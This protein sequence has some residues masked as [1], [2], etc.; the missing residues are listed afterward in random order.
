MKHV[1]MMNTR[2]G[3][4]NTQ[5]S[6]LTSHIENFNTA[7]QQNKGLEWEIKGVAKMFEKNEKLFSD[8]FYVHNYK[9]QGLAKF[10]TDG[11][12]KL[13]IFLCLC[14]GILDD[15]L[16]FPFLGKVTITLIN[17]RNSDESVTNS[18]L[19]EGVDECF[20]RRT[21]CGPGRGYSSFA[22]KDKVLTKFSKSDSIQIT[23]EIEYL[24]K[25]AEFA[26]IVTS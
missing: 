23:I 25:S 6:T 3:A 14:V 19:T 26:K 10:N 15:S 18:Y 24:Y 12:D 2:I 9:F 16:R 11:N 22:A 21:E 17:L 20:N 8:P 1:R 4:L 7:I 13:G 5:V